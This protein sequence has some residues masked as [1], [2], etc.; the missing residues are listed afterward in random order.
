MIVSLVLAGCRITVEETSVTK[1]AVFTT[2]VLL[3]SLVP[4][5]GKSHDTVTHYLANEGVMVVH[6]DTKIVF[7]PL[8]RNSYGQYQLLPDAMRAALFAGEA[9]FDGIDAVFISHSHE[10]HFSA[11]DMLHLLRQQSSIRLYAP[12]QAVDD[13]RVVSNDADKDIFDRVV[14]VALNYQDPPI[15]LNMAGLLIEAVRIP[16]SGWPTA[17]LDVENISWRI[18]LDDVTTVLHLGD[19]DTK[20]VHFARDAEYWQKSPPQLA[21]P[22]YWYFSSKNGSA[23]LAERIKPLHAIGIHVPAQMPAEAA[24]RPVPFDHVDLFTTPGET[25]QI[26][27]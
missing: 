12:T 16:H 21:M 2:L 7:D 22:P 19:A 26:S 24:E 8:F 27:H 18:T 6:D 15:T 1:F 23:V 5:I 9:P 17:R 3:L 11:E 25:R 4:G 13:L 20:D 10:D 14:A